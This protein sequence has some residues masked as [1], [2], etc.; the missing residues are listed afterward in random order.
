MQCCFTPANRRIFDDSYFARSEWN[1]FLSSICVQKKKR[2]SQAQFV[3]IGF[4]NNISLFVQIISSQDTYLHQY[5]VYISRSISGM[6]YLLTSHIISILDITL[7]LHLI[8]SCS[9]H[10]LFLYNPLECFYC[11]S[12]TDEICGN[13]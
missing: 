11:T 1:I 9:S 13:C 3:S 7:T 6:R 12:T 5:I 2:F 4:P 8:M 10:L